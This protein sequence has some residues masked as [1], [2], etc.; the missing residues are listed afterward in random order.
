MYIWM[1]IKLSEFERFM[2]F[3]LERPVDW[4]DLQIKNTT[5]YQLSF[6]LAIY[7][8]KLVVALRHRKAWLTVVASGWSWHCVHVSTEAIGERMI[9]IYRKLSQCLS[10]HPSIFFH[11][12]N[13]GS[14]RQGFQT[15]LSLVTLSSSSWGIPMPD[16]T[17]KPASK[18][19]IYPWVSSQ[20]GMPGKPPM[21]GPQEVSWPDVRTYS[22]GI[23][24]L[25]GAVAL[26]RA[27]CGCRNSSPYH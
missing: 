17:C 16:G 27:P 14:Q 11:L 13:I 5:F 4:C 10:I 26:R 25:Q 19:W 24:Q 3:I 18:S 1:R 9:N 15:S 21:E 23:F 7:S 8:K 2:F 12:S 20:L 22:T 6:E